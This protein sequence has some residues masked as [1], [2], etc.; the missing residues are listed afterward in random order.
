MNFKPPSLIERTVGRFVE[1]LIIYILL[2]GV[3][4]VV[5]ATMLAGHFPPSKDDV[6]A[7]YGKVKE[8][9]N[10]SQKIIDGL[11]ST[12]EKI[13]EI[14]PQFEVMGQKIQELE[15]RILVLEAELKILHSLRR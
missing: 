2:A 7:K 8:V 11:K 10:S 1:M 15:Q 5:S 6:V 4:V 9:M 13:A 12:N 14:G 3:A